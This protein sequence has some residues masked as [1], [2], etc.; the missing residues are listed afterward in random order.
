MTQIKL[1]WLC[2]AWLDFDLNHRNARIFDIPYLLAGLL[3]DN[4]HDAAKVAVWRQIYDLFLTEYNKVN[5]LSAAE[6]NAI[7]LIMVA[8]ELLFVSFWNRSGNAE[9]RDTA[10]DL[11]KWL[12]SEMKEVTYGFPTKT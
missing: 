8:I 9:Q 11:A 4:L 1:S 5:P 2:R 12:W 7:P 10:L 6:Q 3:V